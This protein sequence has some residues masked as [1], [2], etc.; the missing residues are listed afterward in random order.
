MTEKEVAPS[1]SLWASVTRPKGQPKYRPD[2]DGLRAV[3]VLAVVAFHAFPNILK[4][5]FVGVDVF[6]VIS[7]FLI[8]SIIF[9]DLERGAFSFAEFYSRRVRRI[10]PALA[11]V[12]VVT[13]AAGWYVLLADEFKQLGKH[14][15]AGAG[16]VSNIVFNSESGYFDTLALSKPL[17]HLWSL[18]IEEQFYILWPFLLWFF[19]KKTKIRAKVLGIV[20]VLSFAVN[21]YLLSEDPVGDF[22]L[23]QA[24]FWELAVGSIL[25]YVALHR[26]PLLERFQNSR[27]IVGCMLLGGGVLVINTFMPFPGWLACIPVFG[28]VLILSAGPYAWLNR[29]ILGA[30]ILVGVGLISYPLYLW[31]WPLLSFASVIKGD[32]LSRNIRMLLVLVSFGLAWLTYVGVERPIRA[33]SKDRSA[34]NRRTLALLLI[35]FVVAS[36]GLA[37]EIEGGLP[38]RAANKALS[39][40]NREQLGW[41]HLQTPDCL[42]KIATDAEFCLLLGNTSNVS[43]AVIG[44]STANALA[45]GINALVGNGQLGVANIG[46]GTCPPI[47]GLVA[48]SDWGGPESMLGKNCAEVANAAYRYILGTPSIHTVVLAFFARDIQFWGVEG[49]PRNASM[50]VKFDALT[51]LL[52]SDIAR[53]AAAGKRVIVTYDMPMAP[54]VPQ[55]CFRRWSS[56]DCR[57][58]S[59]ANLVDRES[60]QRLFNDHFKDRSDVCVFRQS[61]LMLADGKLR[62]FDAEGKLMMRDEHHLSEFGSRQMASLLQ[63]SHCWAQ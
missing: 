26:A 44:D 24:R 60:Y 19:W 9:N 28:S 3:A 42:K 62:I 45:P 17:L 52:D 41:S 36:I 4:G 40:F 5:G 58:V 49:L 34:L 7:G 14:I 37:T 57:N 13:Y 61:D 54:L 50:S 46:Q 10:F 21:I 63:G 48:T 16:F 55:S 1:N 12:L 59:T 23:P 22:Y 15:A 43:V 32:Y 30:P 51:H 38:S 8:S 6:F 33:G 27:S 39:P 29:V 31:H 11:V 56:S 25:G 35:V 47:R 2:V 18:G 20:L 53:L